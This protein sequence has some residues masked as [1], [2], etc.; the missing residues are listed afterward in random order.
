M[1]EL[2][3][4]DGSKASILIEQFINKKLNFNYIPVDI[5]GEYLEKL[6]VDFYFKK[7]PDLK[8]LVYREDYFKTNDWVGK[9]CK[10]VVLFLELVLQTPIRVKLIN[11][12]IIY[13]IL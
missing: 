9:D 7:F 2:G 3:P 13:G 11:F 10:N 12:Y 5:S 8:I 6:F 1:V 4:G